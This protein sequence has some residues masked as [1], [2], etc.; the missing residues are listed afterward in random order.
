MFRVEQGKGKVQMGRSSMVRVA[1][2]R[3]PCSHQIAQQ[4]GW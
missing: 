1:T 4:A 3:A 2:D